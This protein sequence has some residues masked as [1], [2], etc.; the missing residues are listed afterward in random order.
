MMRDYFDVN[1]NVNDNRLTGRV[2]SLPVRETD[3]MK[4]T[5]ETRVL[6]D[7]KIL[8]FPHMIETKDERLMGILVKIRIDDIVYVKG[9]IS[10]SRSI[11]AAEL[12]NFGNQDIN[13]ATLVGTVKKAPSVLDDCMRFVMETK[14]P[15]KNKTF[16]ITHIVETTEIAMMSKMSKIREGD[17]VLVQGVIGN[18]RIIAENLRVF[19]Q[20]S[21]QFSAK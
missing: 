17:I 18:E 3:R 11:I 7:N 9:P 15:G 12:I 5:M 2:T 4:F 6:K 21:C 8:S 10:G 14:E 20:T 19:E 13:A 1:R 16:I